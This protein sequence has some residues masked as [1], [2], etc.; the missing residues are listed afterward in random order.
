MLEK[1]K[2]WTGR[3][4]IILLFLLLNILFCMVFAFFSPTNVY[5]VNAKQ[6]IDTQVLSRKDMLMYQTWI[7]PW[8]CF[9]EKTRAWASEETHLQIE[10]LTWCQITGKSPSPSKLQFTHMLTGHDNGADLT[11]LLKGF[12]EVQACKTPN[13]ALTCPTNAATRS[14]T[15]GY[16]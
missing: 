13:T 4:P 14:I 16:Q 7:L 15:Q 10:H 12:Q 1:V 6:G 5:R 9:R 11:R 2:G 8:E 3:L